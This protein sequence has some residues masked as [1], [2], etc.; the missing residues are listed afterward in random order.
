[1]ASAATP[2]PISD[3]ECAA[4]CAGTVHDM[5]AHHVHH[6]P[7][8]PAIMYGPET[9]SYAE[10]E[11]RARRVANG[12]LAD[13]L[14]RRA[15]IAI[16]DRNAASFVEV[17]FGA[18]RVAVCLVAL[19]FRLTA[20][21]LHF[22]LEDAE[23]EWLF[24]GREFVATV[25]QVRARLPRLRR[26]VVLEDDYAA[27]RDAQSEAPPPRAATRDDVL[28]QMYTS[29]TTGRPKGV[30]ITHANMMLTMEESRPIWPFL[31]PGTPGLTAMPLF[32]IAGINFVTTPLTF[33]AAVV[34]LRD[35]EPRAIAEALARYR[36]AI[37]PLPPVLIQAILDLPDRAKYDLSALRV[38][39]VAGSGIPLSLLARAVNELPCGFAQGYGLTET[40]G[41]FAYLWPEDMD[42]RGNERMKSG[43]HPFGATEMRI[44][45]ENDVD[46]PAGKVGE[47]ICRGGRVMKGYWK[48]PEATAEA[49]RGGWFHTGDAGFVAPDGYVYI[50]DRI[51][52]MVISGGEN[53]YPAEIE[54]ALFAHP[55]VQ[56]CAVI[57]VPDEKWGEALLAVVVP[58]SGLSVSETELQAHLRERLA[59][60]KVP[61]RYEFTA[62]PLPRNAT[63]KVTKWSLREKY[64]TGKEKRVN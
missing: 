24:V 61:R 55:A 57:G 2:T 6:R 35:A 46:V 14:A 53:I 8:A 38:M 47:I 18:A 52:D 11:R 26:I 17:F 32:H 51:K 5:L 40:C 54:Y 1:M 44:V 43:G 21:E 41:G 10:L 50:V 36:V 58:K 33:G 13:G 7:A 15:R 27:W 62:T 16:L 31:A 22:Q 39:L 37:T 56:E 12:L 19:N 4:A 60:Y 63:G 3:A 30:E 59:G 64:W 28:V 45:D 34:L 25:E 42:P 23:A 9:L 29:G 48:R 49:M 20:P